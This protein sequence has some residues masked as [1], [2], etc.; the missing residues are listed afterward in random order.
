MVPKEREEER[1][2]IELPKE[3]VGFHGT[4][5]AAVPHLLA[6]T[7]EPSDRQYEWLGT[8]FYLWQDSP[9]RAHEW[10]T[11][12]HGD[13]A[14]I[15]AVRASLDGCLDLLNPNWQRLLA[16]ADAEF[17]VECL[18][19]GDLIPA[20]RNSGRRARDCATINWFCD[21]AGEDGLKIRSVRAI[22]EEGEPIFEASAIRTQSHIQ[23]AIRDTSVILEIEEL[24]W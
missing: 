13:D 10:A 2:V 17:V 16:D 24:Q 20:N 14:A 18:A 22:F 9:W 12:H 5:R 21:R 4:T 23:L 7:V 15:V 3:V 6:R 1:G 8:G 19:A 11:A